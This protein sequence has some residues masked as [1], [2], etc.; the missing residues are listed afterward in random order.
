MSDNLARLLNALGLLAIS[1][2]LG[3][4]FYDQFANGDL[5]CPLCLLQ[6]AGFVIVGTGLALNVLCGV[7][8]R[9]YALMLLGAVVG[10]M[11]ALRQVAL[12]VVPGTGSYGDPFLGLHFYT[13]AFV[14]FTLVVLGTGLMLLLGGGSRGAEKTT[15]IGLVAV[16]LFAVMSLGNGVST[17]AECGLGLCPDNPTSYQAL[18]G[19]L[20]R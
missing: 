3:Y 16:A 2:V 5:P 14:V 7:A 15:G 18:D 10:G 12:H 6:R 1:L 17:L 19:L 11:A 13:W 4:A 8:V 20:G 9:H